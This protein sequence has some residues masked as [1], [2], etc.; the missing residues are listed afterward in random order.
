MILSLRGNVHQSENSFLPTCLL[1]EESSIAASVASFDSARA[2][3]G[4]KNTFPLFFLHI[5]DEAHGR[6]PKSNVLISQ[7]IWQN[8][9]RNCRKF[10]VK[11]QLETMQHRHIKTNEYG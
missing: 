11:L 5:E 10:K 9:R 4:E 2:V 1:V 7:D 3:Y 8:L 6:K